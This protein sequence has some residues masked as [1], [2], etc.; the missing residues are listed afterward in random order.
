[1]FFDHPAGGIHP[2][3][4]P[5]SE[6]HAIYRKLFTLVKS[7]ESA[8][9]TS[10][11]LIVTLKGMFGADGAALCHI[12]DDNARFV[13]SIGQISHIQGRSIN[14]NVPRVTNFFKGKKALC[15][16]RDQ[17]AQE[18]LNLT[19]NAQFESVL[20][21][22]ISINDMPYGLVALTANQPGYFEDRDA[23]TLYEISE[24]YASI[25]DTR[26]IDIMN[27]EQDH[28]KRLGHVC[29]EIAPNLHNATIDLIQTFAQLRK[30]Y[31]AQKYNLM[32][33]PLSKAV[34]NIEGMAKNVQDL[35]TL[36]DICNPKEQAFGGVELKPILESI[37]DYNRT[38]FEENIEL[39]VDIHDDLPKVYGDFTLIWQLVY[40]IVQ[41]SLRAIKKQKRDKHTL[42]IRTYCLPGTA[43]IEISD[44]G[45]G[46]E[47]ANIPHIF[48]PFFTTWP[49]CKGLGL[50][51]ARI[52][53]YRMQANILYRPNPDG[54]AIFR[55]TFIDEQHPHQAE[56]F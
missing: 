8:D 14:L 34:A 31:V 56:V 39:I 25:L 54:G 42:T 43:I 41:N 44:T 46:I 16:S 33:E 27:I 26:R 49:P 32:A 21:A 6:I 28:Y 53:A 22:P 4:R 35:R 10:Q 38:Q 12:F 5:E 13:A 48:E 20:L 36:G 40:E 24:F 47:P 3:E 17:L 7:A 18:Y 50:T 37:I 52:N 9:E 30:Y 55:M 15:L 2:P 45:C 1:M 23:F 19:L 29:D 11:A 51:R